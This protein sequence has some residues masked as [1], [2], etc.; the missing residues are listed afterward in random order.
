[1]KYVA[2]GKIKY[3]LTAEVRILDRKRKYS[4]TLLA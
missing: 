1:M 3:S 2:F 4:V